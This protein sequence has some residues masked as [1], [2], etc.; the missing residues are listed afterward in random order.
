[1]AKQL[2]QGSVEGTVV[3]A[4]TQSKGKGGLGRSWF[5]PKGG[6]WMSVILK[7]DLSPQE[8]PVLNLV[9]S[10]SVT[11]VICELGLEAMPRWPNDIVIKGKKV[12]GILAEA[13]FNGR[14]NWVV[15]GIGI[16]TNVDIGSF[17][18]DI[19]EK[20]TSL[21]TVLG[22]EIDHDSLTK[23]IFKQLE[24]DY[25][26]LREGRLDELLSEW[27][28]RSQVMGKKVEIRAR[29]ESLMGIAVDI[30]TDGSLFIRT[31]NGDTRPA[32]VGEC[33]LIER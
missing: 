22:K 26:K 1:M 31:E 17:P 15:L 6:I 30:G 28:L 9:C 8:M 12:A 4:E 25:Q 3:I 5:S 7:P 20:A 11:R 16:D 14:T 19:R 33:S 13:D 27:K 32:I 18:L 24:L 21:K 2:A 10:L 23:R 29:G